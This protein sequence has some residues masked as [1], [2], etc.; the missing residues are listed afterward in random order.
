MT[1]IIGLSGSLR[2][3]SLNTALLRSAQLL[4]RGDVD[5]E[6]ATLHDVPPYNGDLEARDGLP[7][8]V[9]RLREQI[10]A[11]HG[12]LI[13]TPEYNNSIPGVL[14]NGID[15]LSRRPTSDPHVFQGLPVA[16]IGASP[17]GFGTLL[18]QNAFLPV[19]RTLQTRPWFGGRLTVSK[20]TA[21]I[22]DEGDLTDDTTREQL[23]NFVRG[24]ATFA[25]ERP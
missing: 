21:K 3:Q 20:A 7:D 16:I 2:A 6:V 10:A 14:K 23:E 24:F 17:G 11:S 9:K 5:L 8:S 4:V 13:A 25:A 12:L 18:A 15:W 1:R 19:L 22:S